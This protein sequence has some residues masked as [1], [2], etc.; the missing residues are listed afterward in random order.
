MISLGGCCSGGGV[1]G[2]GDC[3][4]YSPLTTATF[5]STSGA[6]T[7]VVVSTIT[8]AFV[9]DQ[10]SPSLTSTFSV[11]VSGTETASRYT[12]TVFAAGGGG[13]SGGQIGGIS[14]GAVVG[15]LL[16]V[17][18]GWLIV[19]HLVKISR[20]MDKFDSSHNLKPTTKEGGDTPIGT[21]GTTLDSGNTVSGQVLTELS[22]QERPQ[23]LE[24]WGRHGSRGPEL[25][26][27]YEAHGVSEL[28]SASVD[29]A[30]RQP[31]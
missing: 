10:I 1:C 16:L 13:L 22:P 5:S 17:A 18:A 23:L 15:F 24:E 9:S 6:Q 11:V 4:R 30:Q 26:G 27:S 8:S 29:R 7:G 12:T 25:T 14:A 28:D 19:R 31:G 2:P 3:T 21:E 20:F